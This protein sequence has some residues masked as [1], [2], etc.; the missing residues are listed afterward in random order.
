M[1]KRKYP[2]LK[3]SE[4]VAIFVALHFHL[5]R[6]G[7]HS[8]YERDAD[9]IRS[10]KVVPIDDYDVFD[11]TLIASMISQSGFTR[12]EFYAAT[13]GTAKKVNIRKIFTPC[14]KCGKQLGVTT[15]CAPCL[16]FLK[17][18]VSN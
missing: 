11:E 14:D 18:L 7:K 9:A 8:N 6:V 1:G 15:S 5:V 12:D 17:T 4:M 13:K 10:R 16:E 3:H 2:P